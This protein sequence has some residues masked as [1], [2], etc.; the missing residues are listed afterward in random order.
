MQHQSDPVGRRFQ[1]AHILLGKSVRL[2]CVDLQDTSA[3]PV[4]S[5]WHHNGRA[6]PQRVFDPAQLIRLLIDMSGKVG[7]SRLEDCDGVAAIR[8]RQ[9]I[10]PQGDF[11]ASHRSVACAHGH[12]RVNGAFVEEDIRF[13]GPECV[14][15]ELTG[16]IKGALGVGGLNRQQSF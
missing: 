14:I 13:V 3:H 16:L 11:F 4:D 8:H 1:K 15:D 6:Y 12:Q 10:Q 2:R 9:P 7:R 5:E